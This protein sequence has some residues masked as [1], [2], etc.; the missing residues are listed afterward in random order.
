MS[1]IKTGLLALL[2]VIA[3][4]VSYCGRPYD[5]NYEPWEN[6]LE[7]AG[8]FIQLGLPATALGLTIFKKD[9]QGTKKFALSYGTTM[10]ITHLSKS[11]I[12]KKRPDRPAYN[13]FPSGHTS[14]AFSGAAFIQRR[15]GWKLGIPSYFLASLTGFSRIRTGHHDIWDVLAGATLGIGTTY[16]FTKPYKK[17][18]LDVG[19]VATGKLKM[20]TLKYQF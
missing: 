12:R 5:S 10:A 7:D 14:S 20:I 6:V 18:A 8:D 13:A 2:I 9:W 11:T 15:Y 19:F 3:P 17:P 1:L 4:Y 16:L